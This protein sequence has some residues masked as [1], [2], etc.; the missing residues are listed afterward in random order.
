[1]RMWMIPANLLCRRHLL[2]EHG[3]IHKH[4]P[5]F[6]KGHNI[7]GRFH[8]VVQIQLKGLVARHDELAEEMLRRGFNHKSPLIDVPRL[9]Y[10]YPDYYNF[11]VDP[12][13]A[14]QDLIDRCEYC[15][16]KIAESPV[17]RPV[18]SIEIKVTRA[19]IRA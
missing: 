11:E 16:E 2:G 1:M 13:V 12:I 3:E 4:L 17:W 19:R 8:P 10:T 14:V 7:H 6:R 5:S 15:A 9:R 18:R